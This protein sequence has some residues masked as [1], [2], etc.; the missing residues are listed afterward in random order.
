MDYQEQIPTAILKIFPEAVIISQ[1]KFSKGLTSSV[2]KVEIQNPTKI[3]VIKFFPKKIEK[4]VE[5]SIQVANYVRENN[6]PSAHVYDFVKGD[7][8]GWVI[9]DCLAGTTASEAWEIASDEDRS[10]ILSNCGMTLK[11]IHDLEIPS[12]WA[13]HKHEVTS[14]KEWVEWTRTR[15]QKYLSAAQQNL[16]K[17]IVDFLQIQFTKLQNLYNAHPDFRFVPLHWDFHLSNI[18]VDERGNVVGVFDFDAAMKGHDMADLGQTVYWLVIQQNLLESRSFE[19][20]YNGYGNLTD[21][22]REFVRLHFLLF[23]AGVT[24]STWSKQH[25]RWLNDLHVEVVRKCMTGECSLG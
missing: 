16:N 18:N 11:K 5:K 2:Y 23:L 22:D 25:L 14:Q 24:R 17:E 20:L 13:H 15:I 10:S 7:E 4:M 21:I 19:Y 6:V 12:C 3:L 9:M 1:A 8:Y